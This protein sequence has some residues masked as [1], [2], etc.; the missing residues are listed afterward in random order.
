MELFAIVAF[1]VS[2][3]AIISLFVLKYA[4][5]RS[6]HVVAYALRRRADGEAAALKQRLLRVRLDA[7][8][9]PPLV[10]LYTRYVVH[11]GALALAAFARLMEYQAHRL[12][13]FVSHKRTFVPRE[14]KSE[15][16]KK[17]STYQEQT[18]SRLE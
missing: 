10:L 13:D 16:L 7:G 15:F 2:L 9:I 11:E 5:V 18:T 8:R 1:G 14:T 4:E 6:G 17:M 12:A 3:I